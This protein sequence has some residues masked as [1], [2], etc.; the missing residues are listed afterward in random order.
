MIKQSN[1]D[2]ARRW[3][4]W[5]QQQ[6]QQHHQQQHHWI[7][8]SSAKSEESDDA[9]VYSM[10]SGMMPTQQSAFGFFVVSE[11]LERRD[12]SGYRK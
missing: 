6:Q 10:I 12:K 1:A 3:A 11:R 7:S 9:V 2:W 4:E 8:S 5:Q